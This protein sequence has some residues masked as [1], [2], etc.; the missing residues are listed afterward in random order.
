MRAVVKGIYSDV[1]DIEKD[2]PENVENFSLSFRVR[3]GLESTRGADDFEVCI[4]TPN[5]LNDNIWDASWGRGLLIVK[6]YDFLTIKKLIHEYV[7]RCEGESWEA[8][9][10]QLDRVFLWEFDD[11]KS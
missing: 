10:A 11:Y 2:F 5:W 4:C 9:V 8:I 6:K 3:I 7:S 1:F